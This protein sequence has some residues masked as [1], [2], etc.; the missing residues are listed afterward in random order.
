MG[1]SFNEILKKYWGYGSFRSLQEDIIKAVFSG[2]DCFAQLATGSGKSLC[3]QVPALAL[4]GTCL[5]MSPLLA[6]MKDQLDDLKSKNI[7]AFSVHSGQSHSDQDRILDNVI[8]SDAKF[9][10]IS[11]ERIKTRLFR[12]R[13]RKMNISFICVDEA[14]CISQ[15]GHDF[16]PAYR[17][18]SELR[19][20]IGNKAILA[21]TATATKKVREDIIGSLQMQD[22]KVFLQSPVRSNLAYKLLFTENKKYELLQICKRT[23]D[24]VIIYVSTRSASHQI[25]DFLQKRNIDA[26]AFHAGLP[27]KQKS[28]LIDD[29][30]N[31]SIRVIVATSA[32]GMGMD[33]SDVRAVIHWDIPESLEAY[34]QEAGR[35]GRDKSYASCYLLWNK[36]DIKTIEEKV[37]KYFPSK[38]QLQDFY[39]NICLFLQLASGPNP[40]E[41]FME[42]DPRDF[43]DQYSYSRFF[44]FNALQILSDYSYLQLT[45]RFSRASMLKI[46]MQAC[47][48]YL[49]TKALQKTQ[50]FLIK[51]ILRN[52]DS[53]QWDYK[54]FDEDRLAKQ[55]N[56][57][58]EELIRELQQLEKLGLLSYK[59]SDVQYGIY[60]AYRYKSGDI[61][62][63]DKHYA[64]S[65]KSF[66]RKIEDMLNYIVHRDCLQRF[67][68]EY[69]GFEMKSDCQSCSN[70]EKALNDKQVKEMIDECFQN[71]DKPEFGDFLFDK[72][73][74]NRKRI[75][76][77]LKFLESQE[78]IK[79]E[80]NYL[81]PLNE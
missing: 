29:W 47:K 73:N 76:S 43:M 5:V 79:R 6:L 16:R 68:S 36:T 35:A 81:M 58:K 38:R 45:E 57:S 59:S 18:I 17:N 28:A 65:K 12:E 75:L 40:N 72:N 70:C 69:F 20:L 56:V 48:S 71:N 1:I 3:Y 10:F 23:S 19:E 30:N 62:K 50:Q 46:D 8:Y 54:A 64:E 14:H 44:V 41:D 67:I 25:S 2:K 27:S 78:K 51:I 61:F 24:S 80:G 63:D 37:D 53:V 77:Y 7:K 32:F 11:P 13:L 22:P 33:K 39:K 26:H 60:I 15:W 55:C 66:I 9:L 42:F 34:V 49:R 4:D 31:N 21:L 52:F 74:S